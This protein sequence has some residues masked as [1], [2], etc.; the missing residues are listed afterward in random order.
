M[1]SYALAE[2]GPQINHDPHRPTVAL[3][4]ANPFAQGIANLGAQVVAASLLDSQFNVE[5][6]FADTASTDGPFIANFVPPA[7]CDVIAIS[8]P[9]EDTYHHVPRLIQACGLSP[10]A[11]RRG[12]DDPIVVAGGLSLI[13]PM[14]LSPFFDAMVIGE[15]RE[16]IVTLSREVVEARR[17]E[18]SRTDIWRRLA[19]IP[20]VYVPSL[21]SFRFDEG[22]SVVE[23]RPLADAPSQV[24]VARPLDMSTQPITSLWTSKRA[25]YKYDDY[26]SLM[27]AMGCHK[28]CPFCVVGQVQ[29]GD[30]GKALNIDLDHVVELSEGR[31]AQYG[32]NIVKLFF[33]SS[34]SRET[35]IDP[36]NLKNL[37]TVMLDHG[38]Q[39]RVGSLNVRQTDE[40]L[41][42]L[43]RRSGQGRVTVAPETSESLRPS[44]G[45]S[46]SKDQAIVTLARVARERKLGL[47]LYTMVGLPEE[48]PRHV[49]DLAKLIDECAAGLGGELRL[50]VS[51]NPCFA[52][53]QTPYE[54][55]ATL[56]PETVRHRFRLLRSALGH[57]DNID[58]VSV[59]DDPMCY[60]QPVLALGGPEL[61][62]V[63]V[64]LSAKYQPSEDDWR[65]AVWKHVG[66]DGRYFRPR[67]ESDVLPWQ[68]IVYNDHE[69]LSVRRRAH[70]EKASRA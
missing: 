4:N 58:W 59:V 28:K 2:V 1:N 68:H 30:D 66:D 14:P 24:R 9:F 33:A 62:P 47:D 19:A 27:V 44:V 3:L 49:R 48:R 51:L 63:L 42:E 67:S 45:K 6:G 38:F 52:K 54:R 21:Y 43:V 46:Y 22:G 11:N 29:G 40:E 25:C 70:V 32:T 65:T 10:W 41:I 69:S 15:G 64:E 13:N 39:P 12:D 20:H 56:R 26:F 35:A 18:E 55:Y 31:R 57:H 5:F 36:L 16:V 37:L 7:A 50:E 61:A 17:Q 53:A 23:F 8:I 60:Y 34:F